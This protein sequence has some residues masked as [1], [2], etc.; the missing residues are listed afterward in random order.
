MRRPWWPFSTEIGRKTFD[1]RVEIQVRAAAAQQGQKM[2]A[3]SL[4]FHVAI[5]LSLSHRFEWY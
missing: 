4:V 2:V 1:R 5:I 3:K